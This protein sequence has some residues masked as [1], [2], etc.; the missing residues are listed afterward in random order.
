[1]THVLTWSAI[2]ALHLVLL[3]AMIRSS[4]AGNLDLGA[5]VRGVVCGALLVVPAYLVFEYAGWSLEREGGFAQVTISVWSLLLGASFR[6]KLSGMAT[7]EFTLSA[8]VVT[9]FATAIGYGLGESFA[10]FIPVSSVVVGGTAYGA[11]DGLPW[12]VGSLFTGQ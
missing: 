6:P 2:A 8:M 10:L 11:F 9:E 3:V 4:R 12:L 7:R 5:V 1:M